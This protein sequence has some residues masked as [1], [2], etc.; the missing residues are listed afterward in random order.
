[1]KPEDRYASGFEAALREACDHSK[2]PEVQLA[3][4]STLLSTATPADVAFAEE[5]Q[6]KFFKDVDAYQACEDSEATPQSLSSA[7]SQPSGGGHSWE[8]R[9]S[10]AIRRLPT[11]APS[12]TVVME[13]AFFLVR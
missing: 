9:L 4:P 11:I 6:R 3:R 1:M 8:H 13:V 10:N 5:H 7:T 2:R 12:T